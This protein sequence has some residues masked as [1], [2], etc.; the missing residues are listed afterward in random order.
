MTSCKL[1][2]NFNTQLVSGKKNIQPTSQP[3][4]QSP[5]HIVSHPTCYTASQPV[6]LTFKQSDRKPAIQLPSQPSASQ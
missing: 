1:T 4:S 2:S 5:N 3:T 6:S